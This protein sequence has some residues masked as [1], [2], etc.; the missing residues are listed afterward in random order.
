MNRRD[1]LQSAGVAGVA[2]AA[3]VLPLFGETNGVAWAQPAA[4]LL[5]AGA[6]GIDSAY[7]NLLILIEL[8]GANDGLN[9]TAAASAGRPVLPLCAGRS[10]QPPVRTL[11]PISGRLRAG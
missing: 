1:F 5:K 9:G 11:V 3:C 10:G 6:S 7:K 8:K 2:G 4:A